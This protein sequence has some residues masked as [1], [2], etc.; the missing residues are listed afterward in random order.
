GL[1]CAIYTARAKLSTIVLDRAAGTGALASSAKIANYPGVIGPIP[2]EELLNTMRRQA[3]DFGAEYCKTT[4]VSS[5]VTAD[6]KV[7]YASDGTYRGRAFVIAT[8]AMGRS[9]KIEGEEEFTGRG[10][11]YCA[12]CDAPFF[13]DKVAA[14]VGYDEV[15]MEEALFLAR[16]AREVHLICPKSELSSSSELLE[17]VKAEQKIVIH[18]GTSARRIVGDQFVTGIVVKGRGRPEEVLSVEGAFM[19][20][21]GTS[22]ITDFLGG[23]VRLTPDGCIDVDCNHATSVPGVYAIGDVTC[24]HPH[25]A[26]IAAAEG[27]IAA[28]EVDRFLS[29]RERAKPDYT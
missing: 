25:Q 19:F 22:P 17:E 3:L 29:G 7:A 14:V 27:V 21:R 12:T 16:F 18:L 20:L 6:P 1:A 11:C 8:G 4:V 23:A 13:Q 9:E 10:V 5:D 15:A 26:I 28:L 2:G 24:L